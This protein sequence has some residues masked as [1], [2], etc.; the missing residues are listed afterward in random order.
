MHPP[1]PW[2]ALTYGSWLQNSSYAM[3]VFSQY[4]STHQI[5]NETVLDESIAAVTEVYSFHTHY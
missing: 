5:S 3:R 4:K 2:E 1:P